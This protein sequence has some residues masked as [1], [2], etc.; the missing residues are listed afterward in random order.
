MKKI[1]K[2]VLTGGPCAGKTTA[3]SFIRENLIKNGYGAVVLQETSTE[4]FSSGISP[5]KMP[6]LLDFQQT[7][8]DIQLEKEYHFEKACEKF[9]NFEH[10]VLICDRGITDAKVYLGDEGFVT[11]LK[12]NNLTEAEIFDRYAAIFKLV[13][14]AN[15]ASNHYTLENNKVRKETPEEA[16][17]LDNKITE[18]WKNHPHFEVIDNSTDFE[19][20]MNRLLE[21]ILAF[22]KT[23][24]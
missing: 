8:L 12:Q 13:T 10:I 19:Q 1:T 3:L 7:Q 18:V 24:G 6:S 21:R 4:L 23:Q 20:K 9:K 15:G 22:L 16:I 5:S 17:E 2:I 14:A 11:L